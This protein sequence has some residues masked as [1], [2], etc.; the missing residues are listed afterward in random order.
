MYNTDDQKKFLQRSQKNMYPTSKTIRVNQ[1]PL[2][3]K[4]LSKIILNKLRIKNKY[5]KRPSRES[6]LAYKKI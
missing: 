1:A 4:E 3:N 2:M 5:F 6:Y